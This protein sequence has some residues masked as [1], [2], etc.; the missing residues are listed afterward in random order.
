VL[1]ARA[2]GTATGSAVPGRLD[3]RASLFAFWSGS[4]RRITS[5]A[6]QYADCTAVM[7]GIEIDLS[8]AGTSGAE[9]I[10]DVFVMMGGINIRVPA[11]WVVSNQV[12][13]VMG[14]VDDRSTG[15][16]DSRNRLI[17][18]GFVMMGGIEVKT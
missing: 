7:G 6:F 9:A 13:A 4:K 8:G 16:P 1:I 12:L 2:L 18:R 10:I 5:A 17:L 14:G 15:P 3:Q 11:D